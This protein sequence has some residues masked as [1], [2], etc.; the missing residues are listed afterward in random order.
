MPILPRRVAAAQTAQQTAHRQHDPDDGDDAVVV[1]RLAGVEM[2]SC[3]SI[4][5][6]AGTIADT[7]DQHRANF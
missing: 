1:E 6:S 7:V 2:I 4:P 5:A 3:Q